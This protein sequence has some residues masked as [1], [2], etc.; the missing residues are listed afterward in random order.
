MS[1][2]ETTAD[3]FVNSAAELFDGPFRRRFK[4]IGPLPVSKKRV[5]IQSLNEGELSAYHAVAVG[6]DGFKPSRME[7]ANRR[8]IA[9]CLVNADGNR[10]LADSDA[11]KLASWDAADAQY[12]YNECAAFVGLKRD[13]IE[14][15]EKNSETTKDGV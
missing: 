10:L 12:V 9:R 2:I 1:N 8:L 15:L 5:R 3:S 6:K 13:E 14:G 11:G 7:D 4:I